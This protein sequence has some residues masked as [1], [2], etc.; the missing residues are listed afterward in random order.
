MHAGRRQECGAIPSRRRPGDGSGWPSL[1]SDTD[2]HHDILK[3]ETMRRL[4]A[5]AAV[6]ALSLTFAGAAATRTEHGGRSAIT[7]AI[8]GDTPYGAAQL[9]EFPRLVSAINADPDVGLAVHLGDIKD[10]SSLCTDTYF[11]QM[12]G[13]FDTFLDPFVLTPGDNDW[14][15]CHRP[16]A[17]GYL[18]TE[19]L[20]QFR[21]V[22]YPRAKKSLG[23]RHK[24]LHTQADDPGFEPFVENRLWKAKKVVFSTVHVVGS[25]NDLV[26]WFGT[27]ETPAQR[28]ERLAEYEARLAADLAWL[29]RTFAFADETNARGVVVA[30]QADMWFNTPLGFT[31]LV[32]RLAER[33]AA[34]GKPVV[35]LEGDSHRFT[36]DHPLAA[37]S[38]FH[39]VTTAAPNVTRIIVEGQTIGEWLKLRID[40]NAA[41][42]FSWTRMPVL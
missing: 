42:L 11:D 39:G 27:A 22:F 13:Y 20:T 15:D 12:R 38:P 32:Q 7:Y 2:G 8:I 1:A 34:F 28:A 19:R 33:A 41:E 18:P 10:G 14:T 5:C 26:P 23:V 37:G 16:A 6:T 17:G 4:L 29:D 25:N 30:M 3:E 31:E 35:L 9:A 40:P 21:A 36:V 24:S